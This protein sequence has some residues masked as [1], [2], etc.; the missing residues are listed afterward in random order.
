MCNPKD[1]SDN[2]K[3]NFLKNTQLVKDK[4]LSTK[5]SLAS[6]DDPKRKE[7]ARRLE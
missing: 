6:S 5:T 7:A 3:A 2:E 4:I 1:I